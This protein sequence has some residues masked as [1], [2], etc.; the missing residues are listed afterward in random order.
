MKM[1]AKIYL[2]TLLSVLCVLMPSARAD[3][4]NA[5]PEKK[6]QHKEAKD[7]TPRK[8]ALLRFEVQSHQFGDIPRKGGDLVHEFEF[9]NAGTTPLVLTR[10]I[11]S[12]SCLKGQ[13]SKRPVAPG[14]KSTL[15]IIY[16]PH[17]SEAGAFNKVIRVCS[18]SVNG[19]ELITVRGNSI[20][21]NTQLKGRE[22][23][24]K[25]LKR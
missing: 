10:V 15:K 13:F 1:N 16:E 14:E 12:C 22:R 7:V 9:T 5:E 8:G 17:K 2:F 23:A 4:Q 20:E 11:T 19:T 18:N 21:N 6:A 24:K 3:A 25:R